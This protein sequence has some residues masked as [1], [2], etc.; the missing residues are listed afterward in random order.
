MPDKIAGAFKATWY[1]GLKSHEAI[2]KSGDQLIPVP[3]CTQGNFIP[4]FV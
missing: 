2:D 4:R 3:G 1:N